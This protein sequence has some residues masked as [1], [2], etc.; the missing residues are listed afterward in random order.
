MTKLYMNDLKSC[1]AVSFRGISLSSDVIHLS[2]KIFEKEGSSRHF[3]SNQRMLD[4]VIKVLSVAMKRTIDN[5]LL[6]Y[7]HNR[8][9]SR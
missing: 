7:Y 9:L 3:Q 4:L 1:S 8:S 5:L 6:Y 2:C